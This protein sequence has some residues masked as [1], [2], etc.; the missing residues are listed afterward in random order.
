[1]IP[2]YLVFGNTTHTV[3]KKPRDAAQDILNK[4]TSYSHG[5]EEID[6]RSRGSH[7]LHANDITSGAFSTDKEKGFLKLNNSKIEQAVM[8]AEP[9]PHDV[10]LASLRGIAFCILSCAS[11]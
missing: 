7:V 6:P 11:N 9:D 10:E 5:I 8:D 1:M 2:T 3:K 4:K